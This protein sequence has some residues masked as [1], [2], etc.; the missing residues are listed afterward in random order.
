M[1]SG[2]G[3]AMA[4]CELAPST[5]RSFGLQVRVTDLRLNAAD[6]RSTQTDSGS[7]LFPGKAEDGGQQNSLSRAHFLGCHGGLLL[8][9]EATLDVRPPARLKGKSHEIEVF[10]PVGALWLVSLF[11][12]EIDQRQASAESLNEAC[13]IRLHT[14]PIAVDPFLHC[15]HD[16]SLVKQRVRWTL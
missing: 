15:K 11:R 13:G 10:M 3:K 16:N 8:V 6:T 14:A 9:F 7:S 2:I 4:L 12:I 5:M 1:L